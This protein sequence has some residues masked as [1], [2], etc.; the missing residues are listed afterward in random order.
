MTIGTVPAVL[1]LLQV[2]ASGIAAQRLHTFLES[3][4]ST[5][6]S[7]TNPLSFKGAIAA[8]N[9]FPLVADVENGW[10]YR[11]TA[12]VT[13]NG[14]ATY[15]N[16]SQSFLSGQE[17]AWNG[18]NWTVVGDALT[19]PLQYQG[20][21]ANAAGF[22]VPT[23]STGV[24]TGHVYLVTAAV[25]DNDGTKTNTSGV[26]TAGDSIQWNGTGWNILAPQ[27]ALQFRGN[28]A[29]AT[30]FP[31]PTLVKSGHVYRCTAGV[32]DNDGT[33]TNTGQV[34]L[35][36]DIIVWYVNAW[37]LIQKAPSAATPAAIGSAAAGT[38]GRP[39]NDD[40]VH[41]HGNQ[42]GGTE[43][44]AVVA[45]VSNGFMTSTQATDLASIRDYTMALKIAGVNIMADESE[46][47]AQL[48][49]D[50]GKKFVPTH[51]VIK[52]AT[53]TGV[54]A[55]PGAINVGTT[56]GGIE[57]ASGTLLTGLI[58]VGDTRMVPIPANT[59]NI[60]GNA[61][62][63]ANVETAEATATVMTVDVWVHGILTA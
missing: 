47:S 45:G 22:P 30:D 37:Y 42:S 48:T 8:A 25:V 31:L 46:V 53:V 4:T 57:I 54:P 17:I 51:L 24:K 18:T 32:T 61:T 43:H 27:S 33:K 38:S 6:G 63:Y 10:F 56:A 58:V 21:I 59:W 28:I 39:S 52:V 26:F 15:T 12:D 35:L 23:G 19:S 7:V 20:T 16:T 49:G 34:F 29:A 13:D 11:I 60:A 50:V 55:T 36:G 9:Q 62:L 14:G 5:L 44:A 2:S 1:D 40:H 3:I 41:S